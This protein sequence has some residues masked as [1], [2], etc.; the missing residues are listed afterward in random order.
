[1]L[2]AFSYMEAARYRDAAPLLEASFEAE[3][4]DAVRAVIGSHLVECHLASGEDERAL[5]VVRKLRQIAPDDATVL[6]LSSKVYMNLWNGAFQ[7][8]LEKAPGSYQARL[9]RAEALEAQERFAEAASEYRE[10]LKVAPQT[11][12]GIHYRL[13]RMIL[14]DHASPGAEEEAL[15]E[16]RKELELNHADVRALAGIGE[17]QLGKGRLDDAMRSFEQA[18]VLQPG[19]VP[20]R[21]GLAKALVTA[22]QWPKALEQLEAAAQ[23]A[24]ED[25]AVAYN[26]MLVYRGL[27]RAADAKRASDTFER[28]KERRQASR[29]VAP[30]VSPR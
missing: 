10:V 2:L 20:A 9:I 24:P 11:Q 28:L 13:G 8:M 5:D 16:F 14:Q 18:L 15:L 3:Q 17:I 21:V 19:Y 12:A 30:A 7:R 4:K 23:L 29:P 27:G 22:K 25:E 1:M 26:L 6:Y